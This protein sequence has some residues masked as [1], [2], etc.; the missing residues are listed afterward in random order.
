VGD[1]C[2]EEAFSAQ[3]MSWTGALRDRILDWYDAVDAE[4]SLKAVDVVDAVAN[5]FARA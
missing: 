5:A 2:R 3:A 1:W 4:M